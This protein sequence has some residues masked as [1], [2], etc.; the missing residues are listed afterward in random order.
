MS[1]G[2]RQREKPAKRVLSFTFCAALDGHVGLVRPARRR[3]SG[4]PIDDHIRKSWECI[5]RQAC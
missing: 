4:G 5:G 3:V 2:Q 1:W